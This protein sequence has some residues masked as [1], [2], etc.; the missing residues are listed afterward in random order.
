MFAHAISQHQQAHRA[1]H[2]Q[3]RQHVRRRAAGRLPERHRL[4]AAA[5]HRSSGRSRDSVRQSASICAAALRERRARPQ[6]ALRIEHRGAAVRRIADGV[7]CSLPNVKPSC[8]AI[9][10]GMNSFD[11]VDHGRAVERRVGDADDGQRVVVDLDGLADDVGIGAEVAS[12]QPIAEHDH[13]M[14]ARA[15]FRPTAAACGRAAARTPSTW[16]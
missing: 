14:A 10:T 11:V 4:S 3:R 6:I 9:I 2:G 16:K 15:R 12:P 8:G 1:E 5:W 7:V 13:R